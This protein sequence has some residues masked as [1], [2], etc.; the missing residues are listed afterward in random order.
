MFIVLSFIC[1]PYP[2]MVIQSY[3]I[4]RDKIHK[5][6]LNNVLNQNV[7]AVKKRARLATLAMSIVDNFCL[8]VWNRIK[9]RL[10]RLIINTPCGSN[11]MTI[12][13]FFISH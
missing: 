3:M 12:V 13:D 2:I 8:Y 7:K 6:N 1:L 4:Y 11:F 9:I 10:P 5:K